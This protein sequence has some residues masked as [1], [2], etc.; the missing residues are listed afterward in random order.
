MSQEWV[1]LKWHATCV[2]DLDF[3]DFLDVPS[4]NQTWQARTSPMKHMLF[5]AATII[6]R[7]KLAFP[8]MFDT[9]EGQQFMFL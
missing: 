9:P 2:S 7:K 1:L 6:E 5:V 3:L 4:G 8:A